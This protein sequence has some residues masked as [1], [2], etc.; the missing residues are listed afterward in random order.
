[1]ILLITGQ[2]TKIMGK[3]IDGSTGQPVPFANVFFNGTTIGV[4]SDFDGNF[5]I[6]TKT[7]SDTLVTS[8]MGYYTME[9]K[10]SKNK[11]SFASNNVSSHLRYP[12]I[13][14]AL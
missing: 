11:I 2:V 7:P 13:F 4:T 6:E 5:S 1:M 8:Y 12:H 10:I 3:V 9:K 14:M